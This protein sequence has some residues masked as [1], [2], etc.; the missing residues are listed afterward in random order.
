MKLHRNTTALPQSIYL[1]PLVNVLVLVLAFS[2]LSGSFVSQP[3]IS[4]SAPYTSF[5]LSPKWNPQVITITSGAAPEI[6]YQERRV[7]PG[8]L[9]VLL[10]G[11]KR[12]ERAMIIRADENA[13]HAL[14]TTVMNLGL[15]HGYS[16]AIAGRMLRQ[17]ATP[18]APTAPVVPVVTPAPAPAA[19]AEAP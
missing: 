7:A 17:P 13:P 15:E 18:T 4:V 11:R 5:A 10:E 9:G 3:G 19:A 2:T 12:E 16:V 14:V 6:Y 8:E 1:V